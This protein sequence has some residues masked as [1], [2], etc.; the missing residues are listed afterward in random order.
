MNDREG[1]NQGSTRKK[2]EVKMPLY[3]QTKFQD[4]YH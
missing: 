1:K 2:N 4:F 3:L